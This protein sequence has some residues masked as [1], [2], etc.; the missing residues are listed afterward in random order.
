M[1]YFLSLLSID[2]LIK[3]FGFSKKKKKIKLKKKKR[4]KESSKHT[5]TAQ[6]KITCNFKVATRPMCPQKENTDSRSRL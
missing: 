5:L 6:G 4:K 3:A 2:S 1:N